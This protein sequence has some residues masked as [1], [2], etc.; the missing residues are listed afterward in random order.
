MLALTLAI[1]C[2][3]ESGPSLADCAALAQTLRNRGE[4]TEQTVCAYSAAFT[5]GCSLSPT[6]QRRP[7]LAHLDAEGTE[8]EH[9]P[10]HLSWERWRPRWLALYQHAEA[11]VRGEVPG[12]CQGRPLHFGNADDARDWIGDG[13]RVCWCP[14]TAG[15]QLY[16]ERT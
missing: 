5:D 8:P 7:W 6:G 4:L 15:R 10:S 14:G 2:M 3:A 16:L 1:A 9:W 11:I 12:P 13:W